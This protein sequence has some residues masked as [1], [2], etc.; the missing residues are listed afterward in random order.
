MLTKYYLKPRFW[1][2]STL[3]I[4][5]GFFL[6]DE[7]FIFSMSMFPPE[8]QFYIHRIALFVIVVAFILWS[9]FT[10]SRIVKM[11]L[12][13]LHTAKLATLGEMAAMVAHDLVRPVTNIDHAI[14]LNSNKKGI[15]ED[16][17]EFGEF[18]TKQLDRCQSLINSLRMFG[19]KSGN[20]P[21]KLNQINQIVEDTLSLTD[22][23]LSF[24]TIKKELAED[25]PTVLCNAIQIEQVFSN[26]I[27]NAKD[28]LPEGDNQVITIRTC[29]RENNVIIEIEDTGK[30]IS[31][32][33][34]QSIFDPFFTTKSVGKGTGLGLAISQRI[35]KEHKG[36][37]SVES[38]PGRTIFSISLGAM[39][40]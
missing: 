31:R 25:L 12:Q 34:M 33:H 9:Q 14:K 7:L 32:S 6:I 16:L 38:Q 1:I 11:N 36:E 35:I 37:I 3:F 8:N 20:S 13:M 2:Y 5:L 29:L 10:I 21:K 22:P 39:S 4:S 23:Y 28:A 15:S 26:L 24:T 27:V 18:V 19:R 40:L 30:G 17:L